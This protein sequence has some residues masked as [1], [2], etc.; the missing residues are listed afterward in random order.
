MFRSRSSYAL[1]IVAV[2]IFL[3]PDPAAHGSLPSNFRQAKR[4]MPAIYAGLEMSF[5]C[6]CR[7]IAGGAPDVAS[8]GYR[9]ARDDRRARRLEW[10]HVVP[11]AWLGR[12]RKCWNKPAACR[13]KN[14]TD[15]PRRACC[16]RIDP[17]FKSMEG[18]PHNL[19]PAIG[20]LNARRSDY[21]FGTV[22]GEPRL[23]GACDFEISEPS[24]KSGSRRRV[25]EPRPEIRGDIARIHFYM[26]DRYKI[27]MEPDYIKIL[28]NWD[29]QDPVSPVESMRNDRIKKR[30]GVSNRFVD[31]SRLDD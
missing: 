10:E 4:M 2:L 20:E 16:R 5:Y 11:A 6:G 24:S 27:R 1:S 9:P 18:D 14:G 13:R 31:S 19:V 28:K 7:Y 25:I 29:G 12:G 17:G 3:V 8:C 22:A 23:F 21:A 15:R 30:T 26:M